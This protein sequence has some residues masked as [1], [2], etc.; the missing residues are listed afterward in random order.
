MKNEVRIIGGKYRGRKLSV[1]DAKGLRPTPN[2]VRE[3]L[4]NWLQFDIKDMHTLDLFSGSGLLSFEALSRGARSVTLIEKEKKVFTQ[5]KRNAAFFENAPIA[6]LNKDA[7]AFV[8]A[9]D[10]SAYQLLFIDPPFHTDILMQLLNALSNK[11]SKDTL[12]YIESE[13]AITTLPFSASCIK[14]KK[15]GEVFYC[16]FR[17]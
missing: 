9:S 16:L 17:I 5:L 4:F 7:L 6:L 15:A 14:Q 10:L 11:L 13:K 2:R 3:T 1:L 8:E 12:L